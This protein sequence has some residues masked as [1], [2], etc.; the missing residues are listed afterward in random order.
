MRIALLG[1]IHA[2]LPALEAV[3]VHARQHRV[4]AIWSIGD[5]VG[6]GAFPEQVVE[7][8]HQENVLGIIG[9]YD[10]KVLQVPEKEQKW[11][12]SKA[13]QKWLAFRWAYDHLSAE[14][15]EYL[16]SLP[17]E[18]RLEVE[19]RRILLTHGS[20]ASNEESLT[21]DTPLERLRE[22]AQ[23]ADADVI[24]FGH[25]HVPFVRRV[26]GVR[27]VNTGSV[28]RPDDG[29]PRACYAILYVRPTRFQVRHYRVEYDVQRAVAA[30]RDHDLPE[31]FAQM[32]LQG[33]NLD[34]VSQASELQTPAVSP[35]A[36]AK[37]EEATA[38][39]AVLELAQSCEYEVQ[40][41]HQV[42]RLAL[43]LFDEL[44][45]VH[46]LGPQERRWLQYAALL[47]D[48][49]LIEGPEGHHKASLRIILDSPLLPFGETERLILG[50][51][52][53]YHRAAL[54][55]KRHRHFARLKPAT[56]RVVCILAAILRVAD[57]LDYTHQSMVEDLVCDV[58]PTKIVVR[59]TV[60]QL[61]TERDERLAEAERQRA[62]DKGQLLELVVERNLVIECR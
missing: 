18:I 33:R 16:R 52:A 5:L 53:R 25:S 40:H 47:H 27:F 34:A 32:V 58:A 31:E 45:A 28:G 21:P 55:R 26:D 14:S 20:P 24:I 6:Y 43:R 29:D 2:N 13:P 56:R 48:I 39:Q 3:L 22:L 38:L 50:S 37:E 54:P 36:E 51:I 57:G 59:C 46:G 12:R 30:I 35:I 8:L 9:N 10:L 17:Q 15:L 1:D 41:S 19:G 4:E 23:I 42:T 61:A 11:R 49:G 44:R 7:R 62:L 60:R